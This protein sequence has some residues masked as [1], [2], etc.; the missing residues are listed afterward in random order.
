MLL[1]FPTATT[2]LHWHYSQSLEKLTCL[3][4]PGWVIHREPGSQGARLPR[5]LQTHT[6]FCQHFML[7]WREFDFKVYISCQMKKF[8]LSH[9]TRRKCF[10]VTGRNFLALQVI[11]CHR[12]KFI[13]T[14][15]NLLSRAKISCHKKKFLV[16]G[17]NFLSKEEI[18]CQR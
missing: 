14:E 18:S 8:Y 3:S 17:R 16:A 5:N 7:L 15:R 10:F 1:G 12:K 11:D 4:Q 9:T 13:V 2:R 6:K